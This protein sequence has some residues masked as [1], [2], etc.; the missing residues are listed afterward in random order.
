MERLRGKLSFGKHFARV[1]VRAAL[2]DSSISEEKIETWLTD[3]R[4]F[5][6]RETTGLQ[7]QPEIDDCPPIIEGKVVG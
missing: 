4:L 5:L 2:A 1:L 6:D 7:S 3:K